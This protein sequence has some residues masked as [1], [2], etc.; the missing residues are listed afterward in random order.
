MTARAILAVI[1]ARARY[2]ASAGDALTIFAG[3]MVYFYM[4][5]CVLFDKTDPSKK[6][7]PHLTPFNN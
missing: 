3:L 1:L 2:S 6:L 7:S 4:H 5:I